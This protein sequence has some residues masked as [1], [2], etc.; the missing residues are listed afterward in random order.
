MYVISLTQ[1]RKDKSI[2]QLVTPASATGLIPLLLLTTIT[3]GD[4][5]MERGG[6]KSQV[7]SD[8]RV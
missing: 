4:S 3:A 8:L 7:E 6:T 2:P 1:G 5:T